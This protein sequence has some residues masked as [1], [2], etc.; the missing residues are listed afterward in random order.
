M[1]IGLLLIVSEN[2]ARDGFTSHRNHVLD[3]RLINLHISRSISR[4]QVR[5]T[6]YASDTSETPGLSGACLD[7]PGLSIG[8]GCVIVI[9]CSAPVEIE[10]RTHLLI[11]Q[12]QLSTS[13]SKVYINFMPNGNVAIF[14]ATTLNLELLQLLT[15]VFRWS[16]AQFGHPYSVARC[17]PVYN[18]QPSLSGG[19]PRVGA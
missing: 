1:H 17:Y 7:I 18:Y 8:H 4:H 2:N 14:A 16:H 13:L 11:G 5:Q 15:G 10:D 9:A 3:P 6:H 12:P 19:D